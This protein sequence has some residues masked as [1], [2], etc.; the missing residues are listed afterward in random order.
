MLSGSCLVFS[1]APVRAQDGSFLRETFAEGDRWHVIAR[2]RLEGELQVAQ[3]SGPAKTIKIQG[4]SKIAYD[5]RVLEAVAGQVQRSLR[6]YRAIDFQR[7]IADRP[8]ENTLRPGVRRIVLLRSGSAKVPF[9]PDGPLLWAEIDLIRTDLFTPALAGLLPG[10]EVRPGD[11]WTASTS[12]VQELTDLER[13]EEGQITC[14]YQT[15][16]GIRVSFSGS[17]RGISEDGPSRQTLEGTVEFDPRIRRITMLSLHGIH[18]LL[19]RDGKPAGRIEGR[20]SLAREPATS[21]DLDDAAL[22]GMTLEPSPET[23]Q[24]LYD[25]PDLGVRFV[26]PRRWRVGMVRGRQITV[27]EPGGGGLLITLDPADKL[28]TLTAYRDEAKQFLTQQ[29][30]KVT[31]T[32]AERTL[33]ST[34]PALTGFTL[35]VESSTGR[36]MLDYFIVRQNVGG[37]TVA[38]RLPAT[39]ELESLRRD[40]ENIARSLTVTRAI[41]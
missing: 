3:E 31:T 32:S 14:R 22:R 10:R 35:D 18:D 41:Q 6:I 36:L 38:V 30:M 7:T 11:T 28:P 25:N 29:G 2:T 17:V 15:G 40:A 8:Q 39:G 16:V 19:D 20:F 23:T 24:L 33:R 13:V 34:S 1:V 27:D 26:Y 4:E 21:P 12:A 37:A 5:E 9:S